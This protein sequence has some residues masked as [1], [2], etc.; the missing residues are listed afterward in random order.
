WR[1]YGDPDVL[2]RQFASMAAHAERIAGLLS[3]TGLWDTGF[4]FGDWLDPAAPPDDP[5]AARADCGVVA[6]ACAY[7]TFSTVARA[8]EVLGED[9]ERFA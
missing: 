6:T 5:S 8:A 2:K 4:Q 9:A 3:P 1:A 7:R